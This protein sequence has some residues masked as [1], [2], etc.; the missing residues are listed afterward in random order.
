MQ[1]P[2]QIS[3]RPHRLRGFHGDSGAVTV[4]YALLYLVA[5][6][7]CGLVYMIISSDWFHDMITDLIKKAMREP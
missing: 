4:E 1:S 2:V 3:K 5:G 7:A 6:A